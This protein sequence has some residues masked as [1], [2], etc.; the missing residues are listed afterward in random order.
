MIEVFL[1]V[2]MKVK[3]IQGIMITKISYVVLLEL[4]ERQERGERTSWRHDMQLNERI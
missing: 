1:N 4:E 3:Y 2:R